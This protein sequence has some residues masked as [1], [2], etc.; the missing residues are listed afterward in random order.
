MTKS[1]ITTFDG[2]IYIIEKTPDEIQ[3][4]IDNQN[5]SDLLRMPNGSRVH[6][7]SI[8]KIQSYDDYAF[9]VDQKFRH[10][11]GQF[12]RS[13]KWND[14]QGSLGVSAELYKITGEMNT[15]LLKEKN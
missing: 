7:K 4:I 13:G 15:N 14:N 10:R 11:K 5:I 2:D 12:L 3:L 1:I 8:S 9:Q 6:K